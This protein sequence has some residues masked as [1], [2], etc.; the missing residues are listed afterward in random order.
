MNKKA[1]K[2][3]GKEE[4]ADQPL[5][6]KAAIAEWIAHGIQ[7]IVIFEGKQLLYSGSFNQFLANERNGQILNWKSLMEKTVKN[8]QF[9]ATQKLC[10]FL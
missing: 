3:T 4:Q 2:E 7:D 5:T 10:L 8:V 6:C 1:N 9:F